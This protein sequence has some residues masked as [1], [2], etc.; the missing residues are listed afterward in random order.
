MLRFRPIEI[1]QTKELCI[2][3]RAD[4]FVCSFGSDERF[5][6]EDG[7]GD[8]RYIHWLKQR[9]SDIPGS[10]VH[11]FKDARIIGQ[12]EMRRWKED[13]N[14]GYVNLFYLIPE[15]RGQGLGAQLDEYTASFFQRLSCKSAILSVSP[16]NIDAMNFYM[17][18]GW[19]D[20]GSREDAPEVHYLKKSYERS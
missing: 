14:I 18:R 12:V 6:E 11:V 1:E 20:I 7:C 5:Y 17:K 2:R 15:C 13:P 4:S 8:K 19:V 3:F 10:C 9:V 16:M